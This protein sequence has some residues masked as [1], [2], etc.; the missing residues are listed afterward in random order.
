MRQLQRQRAKYLYASENQHVVLLDDYNKR[1][2]WCLKKKK[3]WLNCRAV[4]LI[5]AFFAATDGLFAVVV[6]TTSNEHHL[7]P[8]TAI[9]ALSSS[10]PEL[11]LNF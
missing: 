9:I 2:C 6:V 1:T 4:L 3:M 10:T 8:Q 7:H 11:L 5:A